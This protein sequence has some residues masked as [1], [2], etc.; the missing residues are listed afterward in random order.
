MARKAGMAHMMNRSTK[1]HAPVLWIREPHREKV[2]RPYNA[3]G[4]L[5]ACVYVFFWGW[6][7][8]PEWSAK[9]AFPT[10]VALVAGAPASCSTNDACNKESKQ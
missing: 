1:F 8:V 6:L 9:E 3:Q 5:R 10:V 2:H 4:N 7:Q